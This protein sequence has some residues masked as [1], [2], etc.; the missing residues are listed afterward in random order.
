MKSR[1]DSDRRFFAYFHPNM[2]HE[3]LIFVEV[4]LV[5]GMSGG[6]LALLDESAPSTDPNAANTAIFYSISNAQRGLAGI[7]FGNF[8]IKRVVDVLSH[9]LPNLQAYRSEE[10][11]SEL[12]SLMRIS[13]AVFC[14]KKKN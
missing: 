3:P 4:A 11:T 10:H 13:Y 7:S 2:P 9:E 12:Q 6:V 8:L 5:D 14:L 1:L